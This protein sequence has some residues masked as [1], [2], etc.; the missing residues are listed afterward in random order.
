MKSILS[1]KVRHAPTRV[2][3]SSVPAKRL[4]SRDVIHMVTS[5]HTIIHIYIF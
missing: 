5:K 1:Y 3:Y 4:I 2:I